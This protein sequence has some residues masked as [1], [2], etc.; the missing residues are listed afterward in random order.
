MRRF[1]IH[2][3]NVPSVV[4]CML[5]YHETPLFTQM[6]QLLA[7]KL[8]KKPCPPNCKPWQWLAPVAKSGAALARE[9]IVQRVTKDTGL[10][11]MLCDLGTRDVSGGR[12][13]HT[14]LFA[15]VAVE[16]LRITKGGDEAMQQTLKQVV[17]KGINSKASDELRMAATM[18]SH[19]NH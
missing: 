9:V 12:P 13:R 14:E 19:P 7:P 5:P 17:L 11:R 8:S 2:E 1:R 4:E 18:V 15:V 16:A 10:L 3:L 6:L